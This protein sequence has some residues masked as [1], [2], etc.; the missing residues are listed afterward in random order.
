MQNLPGT[1][2]YE[3]SIIDH[4][5]YNW[6]AASPDGYIIRVEVTDDNKP[7]RKDSELIIKERANLEIKCPNSQYYPDCYKMAKELMKK[8]APPYYYL[9]QLHFEMVALKVK[10]TYFFMWTP[11]Y[12]RLWKVEFD[13]DYWIQTMDVLDAFRKKIIPWPILKSKIDDW[14]Q[15]SQSISR[16][17]PIHKNWKHCTDEE[18]NEA[19]QKDLMPTP[20][21]KLDKLPIYPWYTDKSKYIINSLYNM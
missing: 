15:T 21:P 17:A 19:M 12:S 8:K 10:T 16:Q 20:R 6:I 3:S 14:I 11:W 9:A 18:W 2:V 1:I 13:N 7:I 4:P 5:V